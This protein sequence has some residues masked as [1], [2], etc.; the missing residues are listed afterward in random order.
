[1]ANMIGRLGVLLGLDSAEFTKG[2]ENAQ[3]K[4]EQF[5]K[6]VEV[7]GKVGAVAL[8][9]ATYKAL[10]YADGIADVAKANDVAIDS[11]LRLSNALGQ[12]G[13]H[14]EDA[15]KLLAG[16]TK[17]VDTA[18]EGSFTAQ[19]AF[20]QAGI[21][22]GDLSKMSTD[23]LFQKAV[24]GI[25]AIEDPLTRNAK[26]ME[27]FGKAAKGVDFVGLNAA[28]KEGKGVTQEQAK[29]VQDAADA[30][31]MLQQAGRDTA[32]V[33]A[34]AIGPTLKTTLEYIKEIRGES[35]LFGDALKTVFQTVAVLGSDVAFVFKGISDEIAHTIE[36]AKILATQGIDAAIRANEAYDK[37]REREKSRLDFFQQKVMGAPF[38]DFGG[39]SWDAPKAAPG[40]KRKV[41]PGEDPELKKYWAEQAKA[42]AAQVAQE[43]ELARL[44]AEI[45]NETTKEYK[46]FLE[47]I[48]ATDTQLDREQE[49]FDLSLKAT[50][51]RKE[52]YDL[53]QQ[54]LQIE[55]KRA[56]VVKQIQDSDKIDADTKLVMIERENQQAQKAI[57]LAERRNAATK[58]MR[59]GTYGEGFAKSMKEFIRDMP[60]AMEDGQRAFESVVS[61]MDTALR[62]FVR[63]GKLNFNDLAQSIIQDLIYIQLRAQAMD[64]TKAVFGGGGGLGSMFGGLFSGIAGAA[65]SAGAEDLIAGFAFAD[66]GNPPVGRASLVGERGPELFVPRTA[67]TIIPNNQL[68]GLGSTTNV[69][70]NYI[71]AIDTKSFEDRIY[72]SANAVWAANRYGEKAISGNLGR[73]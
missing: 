41:K 17:F 55:Y 46:T 40:V 7:Y 64:F 9:A 38:T 12:A 62:N 10:E 59:E 8:A 23:D 53:A 28:F 50:S 35:N 20:Q 63:T 39:D 16:F 26:A 66:G 2:I 24:A 1:M 52:D 69:T 60:T 33:F 45:E 42:F 54:L 56:D 61:N 58:K 37:M 72:G 13:G 51:M 65:S 70:N 71:Q 6:Q 32:L 67:G 3:K 5:S 68:G 18:A 29:A 19:K 44:A 11:V 57:V 30:W 47:R 48:R 27:I 4:L 25:A 34:T 15:G 36:N 31:D 73:A 22:L 49:I 14:A 21:T 43:Q